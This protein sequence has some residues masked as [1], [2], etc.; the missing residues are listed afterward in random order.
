MVTASSV[1][2]RERKGQAN[3]KKRTIYYV[4]KQKNGLIEKKGRAYASLPPPQSAPGCIP[5]LIASE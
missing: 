2:L 5:T 4:F 3:T 1:G